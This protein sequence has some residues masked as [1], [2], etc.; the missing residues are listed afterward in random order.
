[1]RSGSPAKR[2]AIVRAALDVF[3]R[4]GYARA[5]VDAIAAAAGVSKR[6]IYD[7]YGG[8]EQL[9]V[10]TLRSTMAGHAD[11]FREMLDRTLGDV[12]DLHAA[13]VR[14]G[15]EF[16]TG[17]ARSDER[18]AVMRLMIAEVAHFPAL[19]EPPSDADREE[20]VQSVLASRLASLGDQ[21]L[22]VVPD[23]MEAAEFLGLL[24]TGRVNYRSWYGAVPLG[25]DEIAR[26]VEGGVRVFLRAFGA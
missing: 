8:K 23:P 15:V 22:L 18:A 25:D 14:F 7:Y 9:F 13:L 12:T 2:D 19:R 6:T 11:S 24:L 4:E 26:L 3:L 20:T 1:M 16:A 21:G 10:S 5:G 17:I